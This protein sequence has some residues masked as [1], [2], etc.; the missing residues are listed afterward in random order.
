MRS[1][2]RPTPRLFHF[3]NTHLLIKFPRTMVTPA[4]HTLEDS[5]VDWLNKAFSHSKYVAKDFPSTKS[6]DLFS[7]MPPLEALG[8]LLS[9]AALGGRSLSTGSHKILV[10]D[11]RKVYLHAFAER[12]LYVAEVRVPGMCPR[13]RRSLFGT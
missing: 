6:D 5:L 12:H 11:A 13:L 1:H 4:I 7:P 2:R 10:V 9:D 8:L 3:H